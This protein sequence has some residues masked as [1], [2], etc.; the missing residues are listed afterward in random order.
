MRLCAC[1]R[2]RACARLSSS[3]PLSLCVRACAFAY[4]RAHA[5]FGDETIIYVDIGML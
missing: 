2:V 4:V 1:V 3:L 5:Y